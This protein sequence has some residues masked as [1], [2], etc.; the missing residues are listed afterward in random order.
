MGVE[1]EGEGGVLVLRRAYQEMLV[2]E[3]GNR[4][5]ETIPVNL[6]LLGVLVPPGS[7]RVTVTVSRWPEMIS[8]LIALAA[9]LVLLW[10]LRPSFVRDLL[11]RSGT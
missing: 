5:L 4:E 2:A 7:H 11:A 8:G 10:L 6:C 9:L 3:T 1:G